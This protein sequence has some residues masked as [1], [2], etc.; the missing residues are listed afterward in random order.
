MPKENN[1]Q[2]KHQKG[3]HKGDP[4]SKRPAPDSATPPSEGEAQH[5]DVPMP[6]PTSSSS[7]GPSGAD[8]QGMFDRFA[9]SFDARFIS[10]ETKVSQ[11]LGAVS[12]SLDGALTMMADRMN[13]YEANTK[14]QFDD[15]HA[16]IKAME[17]RMASSPPAAPSSSSAGSGV[18]MPP[19][20]APVL[21]GK[22]ADDC[23]VFIRG[24][25]LLLPKFA[26]QEYVTEALSVVEPLIRAQIRVRSSQVDDQFS[27][28]F[29]DAARADSFLEAFRAYGCCYIDP[30]D[31]DKVEV[32]LIASKSRPLAMRR[33]GAAI[34]PVYTVLED[35][36]SQVPTLRAASISQ[37]QAPRQGIWATEFFAQVGRS[38]APLF[39]L[40]FRE[41]PHATIITEVMVPAGGSALSA[42]DILIIRAAAGLA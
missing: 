22:P 12:T 31:D 33:R 14:T 8:L 19:L 29:P 4:A 5:V 18:R 6:M 25:P 32:K 20:H 3:N 13:A 42:D 30:I 24:F 37:R 41:D 7:A 21:S 1:Q 17:V 10:M 38:L 35:L 23:I 15:I 34:R 2:S 40:K 28:V 9:S 27:L 16:K 36:L 11:E 26:L 39:T